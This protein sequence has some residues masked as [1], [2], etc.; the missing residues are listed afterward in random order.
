M[1]RVFGSFD[2]SRPI[3]SRSA[4]PSDVGTGLPESKNMPFSVSR[5]SIRRPSP[6]IPRGVVAE[7]V[8]PYG[9]D[10]GRVTPDGAGAAELGRGAAAG[11]DA[12]VPPSLASTLSVTLRLLSTATI[13]EP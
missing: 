7:S 8:T 12:V 3:F 4:L 5:S 9:F 13:G 10:V 6:P 11:A 1:R 2:N